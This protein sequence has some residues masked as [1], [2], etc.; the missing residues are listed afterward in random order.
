MK[1]LFLED[2]IMLSEVVKDFLEDSGF[3]VSLAQ[4]GEEALNLAYE[5]SFE[6]YLFDVKT[7]NINGFDLLKLL[8]EQ[9]D[10][11]P[12][13]FITSLNSIDDLSRG[14]EVGCDDYIKKPFEL[15]ELLV[16][17]RN[18]QKRNFSHLNSNRVK[19]SD[20]LEFDIEQELFIDSKNREL[21]VHHKE[22]LAFKELLRNRNRTVS[23]ET[24]KSAIWSFDEEPSD[25]ALRTYIK[26]LR[27]ILTKERI[28]NIRGVGYR[29]EL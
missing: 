16:R 9:K 21:R 25:E 1:I 5:S 23:Y 19:I 28:L 24:L 10:E 12:A 7:P 18:I 20:K 8:R 27:K 15:V 13:I 3:E 17:V 4:D 2:D 11:T 22:L 26:N 6:L 14:F 29:L